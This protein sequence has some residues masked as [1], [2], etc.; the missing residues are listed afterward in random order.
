MRVCILAGHYEEQVDLSHHNLTAAV[1][2]LHA[3]WL[4]LYN[5]CLHPRCPL[6]RMSRPITS[7]PHCSCT[8]P[9]CIL[10]RG[11]TMRACILVG[12]YEEW[13]DLSYHNLSVEDATELALDRPLCRGCWQQ[14]VNG[15]KS[16]NDRL[17]TSKWLKYDQYD[18]DW[19]DSFTLMSSAC[20]HTLISSHSFGTIT[21]I[22]PLA[23][24]SIPCPFQNSMYFI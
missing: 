15:R 13:V 21:Q 18:V 17:D 16:Y 6:W 9:A 4:Q 5:A 3:S 19:Q 8:M 7:Q 22:T 1:Q 14:A 23:P 11:C 20:C 2:C 12:H 24:S 10:A